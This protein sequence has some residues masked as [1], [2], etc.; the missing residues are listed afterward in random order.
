M[1]RGVAGDEARAQPRRVRALRQAREHHQIA[2]VVAAEPC[3]RLERAERRRVFVEVD[4]RVALVRR[5]DEAVSIATARTGAPLLE[6][7][8]PPRSDCPA[9]RRRAA[10]CVAT[11]RLGQRRPVEPRNCAADVWLSEDRSAP[12]RAGPRP[13]RS[14]RTDSGRR[15]LAPGR[16][17]SITVCASANSASRVPLTGS[18]C[19]AGIEARARSDA[20]P[21]RRSPRAAPARRRSWDSSPARRGLPASAA[22]TSSGVACFGSPMDRPIGLY[23]GFGT[24]SAVS[25]RKRSNGYGCRRA[26]SGFMHEL[27]V[28]PRAAGSGAL[29]VGTGV[30]HHPAALCAW[31]KSASRT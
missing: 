3:G 14:D 17:G 1:Q 23:A 13:R 8:H 2:E 6:R 25:A 20:S 29:T 27:S 19:V 10:A 7:Q 28:S 4:L 24:M 18:T 12:R 22:L 31:P 16:V 9:S 15:R 5:D 26:S 21:R 11:V 30:T